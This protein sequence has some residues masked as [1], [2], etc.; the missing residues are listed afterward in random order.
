MFTKTV[1]LKSDSVSTFKVDFSENS[2]KGVPSCFDIS[3]NTSRSRKFSE[4]NSS[5]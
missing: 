4:E 3:L 5:Q 1:V 2:E